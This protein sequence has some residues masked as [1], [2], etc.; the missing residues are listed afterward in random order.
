MA[1]EKSRL[2]TSAVALQEVMLAA[3]LL[4]KAVDVSRLADVRFLP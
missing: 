1:G 3:E 4:P 2:E